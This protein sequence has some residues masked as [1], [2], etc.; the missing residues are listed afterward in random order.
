MLTFLRLTTFTAVVAGAAICNAPREASA[1][2]NVDCA[3]LLCLAGGWPK[4][5]EC[6]LAYAT[7]IR[8]VTPWPIEPPLQ[9]W[10]CPMGAA[11]EGP[12][13]TPMQRIYNATLPESQLQSKPQ[14][15]ASD[16]KPQPAVLR[17]TGGDA[18]RLREDMFLHLVQA[19]G[20]ADQDISDPAFDFVRSVHVFDIQ[21][22]Q[23][24]RGGAEGECYR[25]ANVRHGSYG[26]QGDY[27]WNKASVAAIPAS[28]VGTEG[29]GSVSCPR[30][31]NRSVFIEWRDHSGSY[32]YEQVNY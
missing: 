20:T 24:H 8:R 17:L 3:M 1:G 13:M 7:F 22:G 28:H 26:T 18:V 6:T 23:S 32:G 19:N 16:V 15:Q 4:S 14:E 25:S 5:A 9:I 31:S 2:F 21:V 11:Y 12:Q 30:V 10:R 29:Y 27:R